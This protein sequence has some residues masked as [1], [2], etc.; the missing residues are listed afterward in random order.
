MAGRRERLPRDMWWLFPELDAGK[1]DLDTHAD[2][3]IGRVVEQGGTSDVRWLIQRYGKDGIH[4]FFRDIGN[5]E[6]SPRTIRFWR[7]ILHIPDDEQ[8]A[9]PPDWRKSG[10]A[11][12]I[13]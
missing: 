4:R 5:P 1:L 13:Y 8:W 12:W 9:S 2:S 10:I 7:V 6:L 11:P 3:I